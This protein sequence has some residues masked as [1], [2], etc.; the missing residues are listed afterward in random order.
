M[1]RSLHN[2]CTLMLDVSRA[3]KSM[4]KAHVKKIEW[5]NIDSERPRR[6]KEPRGGASALIIFNIIQRYKINQSSPQWTGRVRSTAAQ[7]SY[8]I[9]VRGSPMLS[10]Y[11]LASVVD[12][13][14]QMS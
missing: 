13:S 9:L 14:R 6:S 2:T 10:P 5:K 8:I 4:N 7:C 12:L 1:E 11:F 3:G